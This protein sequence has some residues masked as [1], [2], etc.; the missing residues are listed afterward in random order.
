MPR[1]ASC[2]RT[3]RCTTCCSPGR[4]PSARDDQRQPLRRADRHR[5]R[6]GAD[7]AWPRSPTRSCCTTGRS[8]RAT[9]TPSCASSATASSWSAAAAATRRSRSRCPSRPTPTS[10]RP[11][12]SRRTRSRCST[13]ATRSSA[14][15]SATWR[16]PRRSASYAA[17]IELYERLFRITPEL[18]AYDLHP[19]YLS[20]KWA[21]ELEQPKVGVQ[22][23]HAHIVSVTAE[24][25]IAEKVVGVAFD[26]TGYGDDGRIWGGE[27][28]V[29]DWEGYERFAHLALR[30]HARRRGRHPA[31]RAHGARH[32]GDLRAARP[33]R[34]PRRC[35]LG[36]PR[37][38]K[39]TL[40]R[41]IER[42]VNSPAHQLDGPALRQR[43]RHHRGRRRRALR[44]RG[45]DPAG[46]RRRP[47]CGRAYEFGIVEQ[48]AR[49]F[50]RRESTTA[51]PRPDAGSLGDSRRRR[52]WNTGWGN[53]DAF[54]PGRGRVYSPSRSESCRKRWYAG[55]SRWLAA[56]S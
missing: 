19:E 8:S 1:S 12:P 52:R 28:L 35:A 43:R 39:R 50:T 30:A 22:H 26:G 20:T 14:S 18:V 15:T 56:C 42:G 10:W 25:G 41:M 27:V 32:A 23:H 53:L 51:H 4:R 11:G 55:T 31:P 13:G 16:T 33:S 3:R 2:C 40:L 49:R 54:P 7:A 34:A 36:W 37:A 46:G 5:Q 29:A 21:L 9:T 47:V 48:R 44:G 45:R 6:R 24:H 17:T 38:R